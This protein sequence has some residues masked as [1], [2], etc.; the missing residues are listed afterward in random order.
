MNHSQ[1]EIERQYL[2]GV[3]LK[4]SLTPRGMAE[5]NQINERFYLG[6]QWHGVS[7]GSDRPLVR[8]NLV[9]RIGDYK[10]GTLLKE[11]CRIRF[12]A[13]GISRNK[14]LRQE[15]E[16]RKTAL[17][18]G[19]PFSLET[20]AD[21]AE[22]VLLCDAL[23]RYLVH[24]G[25]L[26]RLDEKLA[27]LLRQSYVTGTGVLYTY[28][29]PLAEGG[30]GGIGCEVLRIEDLTL[31]DPCE[32]DL[33]RQ[34]YLIFAGRKS[35]EEC[36]RTARYF[37]VP[38]A[39]I[40]RIV[41]DTPSS[42]KV[43][44][45]TKLFRVSQGETSSI[46]AVCVTAKATVRRE[47]DTRLERYP[48]NLFAWQKKDA[49]AYGESEVTQLIPNQIAVN[50]MITASV[51]A[52]MSM[53]MPIMT[54]N[55]DT[56]TAEI[57]NDPGQIIK[58]YGSN[59]DVA[60]AIHYVSPPDFSTDFLRNISELIHSTLESCGAGASVLSN[61]SYNN[62]SAI[63]A[64]RE[65]AETGMLD[66]T[67]RFQHFCEDIALTF[68]DF[69]FGYYGNRCLRIEENG[70]CWYFPFDPNRYRNLTFGVYTE[71]PDENTEK[72]EESTHE[73]RP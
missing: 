69:W 39:E 1:K 20:H 41:P 40:A 46:H 64:A 67:C 51:W 22:A 59:E 9:R 12:C 57:T 4:E 13:Q 38:E 66:L 42:D 17:C 43:T 73:N 56:V 35:V 72:Q 50:R 15:A 62:T 63:Q 60:G 58:V 52:C 25:H 11:R 70:E 34:P 32:N 27:L 61:V 71:E 23:S 30:Q 21:E 8:H 53:G 28:Y 33:Q 14:Q 19:E 24:A 48:V 55:G 3:R 6:D 68:L 31:G 45:Y 5:Q 2:E 7:S 16:T 44:V 47:Y 49:C 18:K 26:V 37:R 54:V 29:D 36:R 65:V 10:I